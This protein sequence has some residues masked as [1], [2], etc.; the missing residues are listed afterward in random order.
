MNV[1]L[2]GGVGAGM[3]SGHAQGGMPRAGGAAHA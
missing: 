2:G 3:P 1:L